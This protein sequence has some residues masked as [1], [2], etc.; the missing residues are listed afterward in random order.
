MEL[1]RLQEPACYPC[2]R[3]RI[4]EV[5]PF[6]TGCPVDMLGGAQR[7]TMATSCSSE[8]RSSRGAHGHSDGSRL[9]QISSC[10]ALWATL[11]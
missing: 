2:R 4:E 7:P 3:P 8:A 1:L 10:P 6:R 5:E 9:D 11:A